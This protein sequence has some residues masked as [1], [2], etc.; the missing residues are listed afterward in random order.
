M[1]KRDRAYAQAEERWL[2][3][4]SSSSG[5]VP[6]SVAAPGPLG[7]E[8]ADE[9]RP[10]L[11]REQIANEQQLLD[12]AV[13]SLLH[14]ISDD[15]EICSLISSDGT[16]FHGWLDQDDVDTTEETVGHD[17]YGLCRT[18]QSQAEDL[19]ATNYSACT[20]PKR[21][22]MSCEIIE[23]NDSPE[24]ATDSGVVF[25]QSVSTN[26]GVLLTNGSLV[27]AR[28]FEILPH[29]EEQALEMVDPSSAE[30][31]VV[32]EDVDGEI[33]LA[34]EHCCEIIVSTQNEQA[35]L[36]SGNGALIR[37]HL[38]G[39][40]YIDGVAGDE[41]EEGTHME[42][43]NNVY[44]SDA[45]LDQPMVHH[46]E[47][48]EGDGLE[49]EEAHN[50]NDNENDA[51]FVDDTPLEE[52]RPDI[53]QVY[54]HELE[55]H[56][57]EGEE[58][59]EIQQGHH[60]HQL[61][62]EQELPLEHVPEMDTEQSQQPIVIS[63][64][65]EEEQPEPEPEAEHS[66]PT[67][68]P[69]SS[70]STPNGS[71][72]YADFN[73]GLGD[74]DRPRKI[75]PAKRKYPPLLKNT[76]FSEAMDR[77]LATICQAQPQMSLSEKVET[78]ETATTHD[79]EAVEDVENFQ[80]T[81]EQHEASI[82]HQRHSFNEFCETLVRNMEKVSRQFMHSPAQS[83]VDQDQASA[84]QGTSA[85]EK[86]P[87]QRRQLHV[88]PTEDTIILDEDDE[89]DCYEVG[90]DNPSVATLTPEAELQALSSEQEE[91][92]QQQ[93]LEDFKMVP[94]MKTI[95]TQT[96][97]Q[98]L[99]TKE[100]STA[101]LAPL[102]VASVSTAS[103]ESPAPAVALAA[104]PAA[105]AINS[106]ETEVDR[107]LAD[108]VLGLMRKNVTKR[109]KELLL[110]EQQHSRYRE[111]PNPPSDVSLSLRVG[112]NADAFGD[113]PNDAMFYEQ[114]EFCN[115][116]GLTEMSTANA[117]ATAMRELANSTVARRSLRVRPQEQLDRMRCDV[118]GKRK[119]RKQQLQQLVALNTSSEQSTE[120][121]AA[122]LVAEEQR[123]S[124]Q[125][126]DQY[127]EAQGDHPI[128]SDAEDEGAADGEA[129]DR[130]SKSELVEAAF[131]QVYAAVTPTQDQLLETV[132]QQHHQ[133]EKDTRCSK[134]E[135]VEAAFAQVYAA[136]A[137]AREELL[138]CMQKRLRQARETKPSIYIVQSMS[139]APPVALPVAQPTPRAPTR[140]RTLTPSPTRNVETAGYGGPR[141]SVESSSPDRSR[142]LKHNPKPTKNQA[143]TSKTPRK[144]QAESKKPRTSVGASSPTKAG[145]PARTR[146]LVTRS[147]THMNSKLLRNRKV[148]LLKSYALS[149]ADAQ[150]RGKRLSGGTAAGA[151][152]K[153]SAKGSAKKATEATETLDKKLPEQHRLEQQQTTAAAPPHSP[154]KTVGKVTNAVVGDAG[155]NRPKSYRRARAHTMPGAGVSVQTAAGPLPF[156]Q[157]P[158]S[159]HVTA[160]P[161][162]IKAL[163]DDSQEFFAKHARTSPAKDLVGR[164]LLSARQFAQPQE[165]L[166]E[167]QQ[168]Y[169]QANPPSYSQYMQTNNSNYAQYASLAKP[170]LVYPPP[171][172]SD[173]GQKER[174]KDIHFSRRRP[175]QQTDNAGS[176][177][178][179]NRTLPPG[180]MVRLCDG[181]RML[182]NPLAGK[183]GKVLYIY[184]ELDQLIVL[185]EHCVSFWK[186]SKVFNVLHKPRTPSSAQE[187]KASTHS[188]L[189]GQG[190][191]SKATESEHSY[192]EEDFERGPRWV[193]LGK[194][195]R[196]TNDNEVFAPF[197]NRLCV[198]N[199]TPVYVEMRCHP[200][201]HHKRE[202]TLTS[203]HVNVYYYCEE[204]LRPKM[205][206]VH[207]DAVSCDGSHV[208]FTSIA[209]SR[210]FVVA[211]QQ[212]VV[213]GKPRSGICKYSLTPTLD[214]LASIRE[215]KQLRHELKHIECLTEDR[216][217][218]YG[219]T[220]ITIWDHRSGDT[221]MNYD[222]C[223]PLGRTLATMH[224]P[225]FEMDQSSMLV[226]YQHIESQEQLD[227][228]SEVH[229]IACELSHATPSHR[230]LQVHRLPTPQFNEQIQAVNTGDHLILKAGTGEEIWISSADP[231]QLTYVAPQAN[232]SQRFYARH[233]SQVI[234]L[235]PRTL[236]V[237]SI[238]NH[239]LQ[240]AVQQQQQI[241]NSSQ[242][243]MSASGTASIQS[244][245]VPV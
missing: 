22:R 36:M 166:L 123:Q 99:A 35:F 65:E 196:I 141:P 6:Q 62:L 227:K 108:V 101:D 126:Y 128:S 169:M 104:M 88:L 119:K 182:S 124:T 1:S 125:A 103:A 64:M 149:D 49:D 28:L 225:S 241:M 90:G 165:P 121:Q 78:W 83:A 45:A 163:M 66:S 55:D 176:Y 189:P 105:I 177:T 96:S 161:H 77:R 205:H 106:T 81:F 219:L 117:V 162:Q 26:P 122:A 91:Q 147:T 229:V 39:S 184:Y 102:A 178:D 198:H 46:H 74:E 42:A 109:H 142:Q 92:Q 67:Q 82:P 138:E 151:A 236:T 175:S 240:L 239:M 56:D 180:S 114:Q 100:T 144:S 188:I 93:L 190:T 115:Y 34:E 135:L 179:I 173:I 57:N 5:I 218:G 13:D 4:V 191:E 79:C 70:S 217:I 232:G 43:G 203:L 155:G 48:V 207:L 201:D 50:D 132:Q 86:P 223:C 21:P 9:E 98:R 206:S 234:E 37:H 11:S 199:S 25:M 167:Q 2:D 31:C 69:N 137:P 134:S 213:M 193:N 143:Q 76:L 10:H 75:H 72:N 47:L 112:Q 18:M 87:I 243:T 233:K 85:P 160:D 3:L 53:C 120:E 194:L 186:Y 71:D 30:Q 8:V 23:I 59:D 17:V 231:R 181:S 52:E 214:T 228:P 19:Q 127:Y 139:N 29:S 153:K 24:A 61:H 33:V 116:L 118:R 94:D 209:E 136:A 129:D 20:P 32:Y 230:L 27:D 242:S 156:A 164:Y 113:C 192:A 16:D 107:E 12:P 14:I 168:L 171:R 84:S 145:A 54:D 235:S 68:F 224:Y 58:E 41:D 197:G 157:F 60:H 146:D 204:E 226:L 7:V 195:R 185:Q 172:G 131:A 15:S 73:L 220:R 140:T 154:K 95:Q 130:C 170:V 183:H 38:N 212:E 221:L 208:I 152:P 174:E 237:D 63:D 222:L 133:P 80:A 159:L 238:A 158:S 110:E 89:D 97:V 40:G 51:N 215:F 211:W 244:M 245:P 200:L 148:S 150:G 44:L 210:Y 216:L 187:N 202:V 111:S